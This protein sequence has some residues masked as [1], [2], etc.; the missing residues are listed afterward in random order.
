M[1]A[2]QALSMMAVTVAV[3][4]LMLLSSTQGAAT[5]TSGLMFAMLLGIGSLIICLALLVEM[6]APPAVELWP[7]AAR[8]KQRKGKTSVIKIRLRKHELEPVGLDTG[9]VVASY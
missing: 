7:L 3:G 9:R 6:I 1:I 8:T 2:I 5:N 4:G